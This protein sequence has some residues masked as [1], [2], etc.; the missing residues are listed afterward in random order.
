[1]LVVKSGWFNVY[2]VVVV[3][4]WMFICVVCVLVFVKICFVLCRWFSVVVMW[5]CG[6]FFMVVFV[7]GM[8]VV[9][10]GVGGSVV[11]VFLWVCV[12]CWCRLDWGCGWVWLVDVLFVDGGGMVEEL[13]LLICGMVIFE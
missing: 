8:W 6:S 3:F 11:R 1:M 9:F 12:G 13:E 10:V 4:V 2:C 7:V 5:L